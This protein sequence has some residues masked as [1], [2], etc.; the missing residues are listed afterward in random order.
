MSRLKPQILIHLC[1]L[2]IL[3]TGLLEVGHLSWTECLRLVVILAGLTFLFIRH[4]FHLGVDRPSSIPGSWILALTM[5]FVITQFDPGT[6]A[7]QYRST[8]IG[9]GP[10]VFISAFLSLLV[11]VLTVYQY[12]D[13]L[14]FKRLS[15]LDRVVAVVLFM[16][17]FLMVIGPQIPVPPVGIAWSSVV[18][19]LV[20]GCLWF[21]VTRVYSDETWRFGSGILGNHWAVALVFVCLLF[22]P[23]SIFGAYRAYLVIRQLSDGQKAYS[24]QRWDDAKS[25]YR[26]ADSLNQTV[27]LGMAR[28]R[29]LRDLAVINLELGDRRAAR[30]VISAIRAHTF[31]P[32]DAERKV[33]EVYTAAGDWERVALTL[34]RVLKLRGPAPSLLDALGHAHLKRR[35]IRSYIQA[36]REYSYS[37]KVSG[38]TAEEWFF[39]G[40]VE[41]HLSNYGAALDYFRRSIAAT[42][43]NA[44]AH[45]K[46]GRALFEQGQ[47][48]QAVG[49]YR[50]AIG[51]EGDFADAYY[52]VGLCLE[53]KGDTAGAL[54]KYDETVAL[55]PNHLDGTIAME[56]LSGRS[57][58]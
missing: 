19:V 27:S 46:V 24:E 47:T 26:S 28:D 51:L 35:N 43:G 21:G 8:T 37:P 32:A 41:M 33:A 34:K 55:L 10:F 56:R 12:G 3:L 36:V 44:H 14:V 54:S 6:S 29:Y 40:N 15:S 58:E 20:Y 7:S 30:A 49:A 25:H 31:D 9:P 5:A 38:T 42:P 22:L 45:Y 18:K 2:G 50:R 57:G 1:V 4:G 53:A 52:R 17:L 16:A 48:D 23:T 39:L 11:G 13:S